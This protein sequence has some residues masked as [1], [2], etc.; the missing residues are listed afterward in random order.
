MR[1]GLRKFVEKRKFSIIIENFRLDDCSRLELSI[2]S[3]D[4][5]QEHPR[6][7]NKMSHLTG[8]YHSGNLCVIRR[9]YPHY[10]Q[11][12]DSFSSIAS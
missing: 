12:V 4:W 2:V 5:K 6:R 11:L 8:I 1:I 9:S 7:L 3:N 10:K